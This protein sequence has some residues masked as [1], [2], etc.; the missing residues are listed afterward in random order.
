[1][2]NEQK[3][4]K[5]P[6]C[7]T[8][9]ERSPLVLA[10]GFQ[11]LLFSLHDI[12][13]ICLRLHFLFITIISE[14]HMHL[15]FHVSHTFYETWLLILRRSDPARLKCNTL[16]VAHD[17]ETEPSNHPTTSSTEPQPQMPLRFILGSTFIAH[18]S[19]QYRS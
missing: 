14:L 1:M 3:G 11:R 7:N 13:A 5:D 18:K 9:E 16:E 17:I 6:N 2:S 8:G 4:K 15:H 10:F 19:R 12:T